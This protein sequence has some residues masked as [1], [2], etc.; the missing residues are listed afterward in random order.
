MHRGGYIYIL[1]NKNNTVLYV[2]V[3]SHLAARTWEHKSKK[4]PKSFTARYNVDKL[5]FFE[6]YSR[7]EEAIIREKKIKGGSR[8]KKIA[9][10]DS[11]NPEW[12][13]LYETILGDHW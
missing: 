12:N 2:G 10:I 1:T 9:L 11:M 8:A 3:T 6:S 5:V 4:D 7:I 13:D